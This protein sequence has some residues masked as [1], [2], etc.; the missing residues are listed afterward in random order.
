MFRQSLLLK[1][2]ISKSGLPR[3]PLKIA[4]I[5]IALQANVPISRGAP[6]PGPAAIPSPPAGVAMQGYD[7][8]DFCGTLNVLGRKTLH[9]KRFARHMAILELERREIW[10]IH[11]NSGSAPFCAPV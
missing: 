7:R 2:Y 9:P 4:D 5:L 1:T 3:N 10:Q 8:A 6:S 11:S